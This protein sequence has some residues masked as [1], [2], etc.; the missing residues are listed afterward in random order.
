[1]AFDWPKKISVSAGQEI[2]W[3]QIQV[4]APA[5]SIADLVRDQ[6]ILCIARVIAIELI[7]EDP[8]LEKP[9]HERL[10]KK[11]Q[12]K[13]G[14]VSALVTSVKHCRAVRNRLGPRNRLES[15]ASIK[16]RKGRSFERPF[17]W[18]KR[19]K[20]FS[21]AEQSPQLDCV[22]TQRCFAISCNRSL[23]LVQ[24][25]IR[26]LELVRSKKTS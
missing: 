9:D 25:R 20:S 23:V 24:L 10:R 6:E 15:R 26:S 1:M 4:G 7:E 12:G 18:T 16:S 17:R 19:P 2:C 5:L 14:S 11:V 8:G 13:H 3:V 22:E 21:L